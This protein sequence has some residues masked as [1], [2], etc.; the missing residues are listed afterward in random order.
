M[1]LQHSKTCS[2][3]FPYYDNYFGLSKISHVT[4][5]LLWYIDLHRDVYENISPGINSKFDNEK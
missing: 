3:Q 1:P 5:K 2:A 4:L